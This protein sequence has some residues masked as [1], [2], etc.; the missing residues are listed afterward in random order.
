MPLA[1]FLALPALLLGTVTPAGTASGPADLVLLGGTVRTLD[2]RLPAASALAVSGGRVAAVGTEA[3]VRPLI[4]PGT[5]V[6]DLR[7]GIAYPGFVD[8]HAHVYGLGQGLRHLDLTQAG[9]EADVA[10]MVRGAAQGK[11]PGEWITGRGWDQNKWDGK[12][13]PSRR[14]ISEAAPRNPVVLRRVDGHAAWANDAALELAGISE[15]GRA[16]G[17]GEILCNGRGVPTGILVDDAAD[18]VLRLVPEDSDSDRREALRQAVLLCARLGLTGV[19]DAGVGPGELAAYRRLLAGDGL[20]V[21]I[22]AM[23]EG[24]EDWLREELGHGPKS[25][26]DG[27]LV[28][29]GVKMYADGALGSRGAWLLASYADRPDSSGLCVTPPTE[30][31]RRAAIC[32]AL[33]LQLCTHAIGDRAVRETLDAYEKALAPLPD[34]KD[35]RFRIEHAQIVDPADLPRFAA[36]GVVPSVQPTHCTSD[37][38]W[39]PLRLGPERTAHAY[40][41]RSF[42]D[43]GLHIP[44]G[45]DF[46]VEPPDPLYTFYAA[47]TRQGRDGRPQP[48]WHPEQRLTREEALLAMTLWAAE[49][50]FLEKE[51]GKLAPGFRADVTVLDAD[52]LTVPEDRIL[53]SRVLFAIVAGRVVY[54]AD[55]VR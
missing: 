18:L 38:P 2:P 39:A 33:G 41:W 24:P 47:V 34:G 8:A 25:E 22:W 23:L 32:A 52:L 20:P 5:R 11:A 15:K 49:A 26:A 53:K 9:S 13:F 14:S 54:A 36:L 40:T 44:A 46:P 4:G 29:G 27:R 16:V 42:L 37:M 12:A 55:A 35:R 6:V 19:H 50:A 31:A 3:Q 28:L 30:M 48:G 21:R 10:A 45:T 7:G 1:L 51:Q 43:R 17:G